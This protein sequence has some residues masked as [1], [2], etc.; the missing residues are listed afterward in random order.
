MD[1][2]IYEKYYHMI[3]K[4]EVFLIFFLYDNKRESDIYFLSL[5]F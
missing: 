3:V 4:F 2:Y 5:V 1:Y